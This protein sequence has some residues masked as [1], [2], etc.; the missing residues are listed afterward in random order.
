MD[1]ILVYVDAENISKA[2]FEEV[3]EKLNSEENLVLGKVYGG[4]K[5]LGDI[6][7]A[8]LCAGYEYVDTQAVTNTNKNVTDMK[9]VVDCMSDVMGAP[10]GTYSAIWVLS[11]DHDFLPLVYKLSGRRIKVITPFLDQSE[12]P[13]TVAEVNTYLHDMGF[14][15][16]AQKE[17]MK[18]PLLLFRSILPEQFTDK[19]IDSYVVSK[20]RK[21]VKKLY[22]R[23]MPDVAAK[24]SQMEK[25]TPQEV[26]NTV[27]GGGLEV[28]LK[29]LEAYTTGMFGIS[30]HRNEMIKQLSAV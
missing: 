6:L 26:I 21:V 1:N 29:V 8:C 12:K 24:V 10:M 17:I 5:V 2:Q 19:L 23:D 25:F 4:N 11:A 16:M 18:D 22:E 27:V 3:Q 13:K 20:K 9:I 30:L 7:Q 15:P 28:Q 14:D